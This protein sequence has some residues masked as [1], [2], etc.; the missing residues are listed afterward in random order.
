M[1]CDP[2]HDDAIAMILAGART[3]HGNFSCDYVSGN[4]AVVKIHVM[5]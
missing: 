3:S 1:D 5:H 4:Q 2:G